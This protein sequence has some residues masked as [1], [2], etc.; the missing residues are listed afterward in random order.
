MKWFS[1]AS[2]LFRSAPLF[3]FGVIATCS[4]QRRLSQF[5]HSHSITS[6]QKPLFESSLCA[7]RLQPTRINP[8][9][10]I[11]NPKSTIPSNKPR[12]NRPSLRKGKEAKKAGQFKNGKRPISS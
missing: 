2:T 5:L 3:R 9:S 1:L 8:Q 7:S 12:I 11:A 10:T 6:L 4:E